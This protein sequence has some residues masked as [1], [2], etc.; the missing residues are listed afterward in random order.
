[1]QTITGLGAAPAGVPTG[2]A[3]LATDGFPIALAI[4]GALALVGMAG[5]GVALSR[6]SSN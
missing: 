5:S 4:A 6:R 1:V 3:G 2:T